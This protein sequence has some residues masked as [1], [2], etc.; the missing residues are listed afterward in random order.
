M[1]ALVV[2][3]LSACGLGTSSEESSGPTGPS[4]E[5]EPQEPSATREPTPQPD[6]DSTPEP[7][8][9]SEPGA[10]DTWARR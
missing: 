2:G 4:L 5:V 3:V 6:P 7:E 1:A 8:E 10:P 9:P